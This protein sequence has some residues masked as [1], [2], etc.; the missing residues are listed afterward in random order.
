MRSPL[1]WPGGKTRAVK[2]LD[3]FFPAEFCSFTDPMVGGG[4]VSFFVSQKYDVPVWVNDTYTPLTNFWKAVAED[5]EGLADQARELK[6]T[7]KDPREHFGVCKEAPEVPIN[8]YYLNRLSFSG[9]TEAGSFTPTSWDNH[10]NVSA[11]ARLADAGAVVKDWKITNKDYTECLTDHEDTF[12]YLDP[13][14]DIDSN[15]YGK[16]GEIHKHFHH[17]GFQKVIGDLKAKVLVSYNAEVKWDNWK[18]DEF[19]LTYTMRSR[20]DYLEE[21]K[22]R[23]EG[24]L[25]NYD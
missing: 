7:L 25:R 12:I 23:W 20:G 18:V 2:K 16:R 17:E 11:F 24:V 5:S 9:L 10:F 8:F 14:Y 19:P 6:E 21:Q 1:R 22:K 3:A 4:S 15:L 13:P